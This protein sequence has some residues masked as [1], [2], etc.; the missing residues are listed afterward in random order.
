[1][2][3]VREFYNVSLYKVAI[4]CFQLMTSQFLLIALIYKIVKLD[5]D[6]IVN[7]LSKKDPYYLFDSMGLKNKKLRV[8]TIS[9]CLYQ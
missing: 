8:I 2:Y 3:T 5:S 7:L 6:K 9:F 4:A 1:M